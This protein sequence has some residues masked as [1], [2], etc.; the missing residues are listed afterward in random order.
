MPAILMKL[1]KHGLKRFLNAVQ[2]ELKKAGRAG[3]Y[4]VALCLL[5]VRPISRALPNMLKI[6]L[7]LR[8]ALAS[9]R[10]YGGVAENIEEPAVCNGRWFNVD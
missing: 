4:Q 3:N 7:A 8:L 6:S 2:K 10:G 1:S 9:R 5:A